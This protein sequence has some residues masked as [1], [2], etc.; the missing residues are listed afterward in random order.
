M[1]VDLAM[2]PVYAS[3]EDSTHLSFHYDFSISVIPGM[4]YSSVRHK[5]CVNSVMTCVYFLVWMIQLTTGII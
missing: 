2:T 4:N 5:K 3:L 1:C